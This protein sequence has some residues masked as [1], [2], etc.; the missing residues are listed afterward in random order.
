[1]EHGGDFERHTYNSRKQLRELTS[2]GARFSSARAARCVFG[3]L[4]FSI[5][6]CYGKKL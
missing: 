4:I 1:M 5:I 2:F 3:V 6:S